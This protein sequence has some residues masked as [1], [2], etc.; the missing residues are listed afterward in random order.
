MGLAVSSLSCLLGSGV[1]QALINDFRTYDTNLRAKLYPKYI[2]VI[3]FAVWFGACAVALIFSVAIFET[4]RDVTKITAVFGILGGAYKVD[5][6][7]GEQRKRHMIACTRS[8][9]LYFKLSTDQSNSI[10]RAYE[11][12]SNNPSRLHVELKKIKGNFEALH[13]QLCEYVAGNEEIQSL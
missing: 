11:Q 3:R 6:V 1:L 10:A 5:A 8:R 2:P 4:V 9:W 13:Q 12:F 7:L